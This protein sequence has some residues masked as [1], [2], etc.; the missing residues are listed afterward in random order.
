MAAMMKLLV[1][2]VAA[3]VMPAAEG[4]G[5]R[6]SESRRPNIVLILADDL[7]W[8]DLGCYGSSFYET[9]HLD[10][11]A[12]G[13]MRFTDA[14]AASPVCAPTRA[15]IHTGK[16]P[17]RLHLT[18]FTIGPF[19]PYEKL[20]E[21]KW[22]PFMSPAE[23]TL[24][25]VLRAA[26]YRTCL[27][28]KWD[29]GNLSNRRYH[30]ANHGFDVVIDGW[31]G[32]RSYFSPYGKGS[33]P[34]GPPGEYLTDRQTEEAIKFI[35]EN[36]GRPFYL[37]LAY[38]A[39]HTTRN[40]KK[41]LEGKAEY[42]EKYRRK[43]LRDRSQKEAV[44]AA[45]VQS[46]DDGVGRIIQT[47]AEL[48]LAERTLVI[49]SSDNGGYSRFTNN[50]PLRAGKGVLYEGG[51]R[52]PLIVYWPGR[53][54]AGAVCR[55]PVSSVDFYPTI[56][57]AAGIELETI[58]QRPL[59]GC[60]LKALFQDPQGE[61]PREALFWH[62]P[63]YYRT[64]R[65][66]PHSAVRA[67]NYKLI[68]FYADERIELYDL[69]RD[70]GE[71]DNLADQHPA[72]ADRLQSLLDRWLKHVGAALPVPNPDHDPKRAYRAARPRVVFP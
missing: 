57:R 45:M 29:V 5:L 12:A 59:D 41:P 20:L 42:V 40:P 56:V 54:R 7:G 63:H 11:L 31:D 3:A 39:V 25:E 24:A 58:E 35:Q 10:R 14:Y 4:A 64:L 34:D 50:W 44:Y 36:K 68:K 53:V 8:R 46:V 37:Y 9:P 19:Y 23:Q 21:P 13:G 47:L 16:H 32:T 72:V 30:P 43:L 26:G 48:D 62:Y 51:I 55:V 60:D 67:G 15:S 27:V 28:G 17:A 2:V 6:A 69:S 66:E 33:L 22:C 65:S 49:F 52:V 61:L 70:L 38:N 71:R 18:N 1:S